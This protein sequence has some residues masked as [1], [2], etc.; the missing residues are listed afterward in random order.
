MLKKLAYNRSARTA[1]RILGAGSTEAS[2]EVGQYLSGKINEEIGRVAGTDE[3]ANILDAVGEAF[4]SQ[5]ALEN[6]LQGLFGGVGG[7]GA[8]YS[9][10]SVS[11]AR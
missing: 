5:D 6:A 8:M 1:F 11:E 7:S 3:D 10:V 4:M 2:T 9:A